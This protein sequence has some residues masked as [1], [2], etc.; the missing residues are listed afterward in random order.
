MLLRRCGSLHTRVK[1]ADTVDPFPVTPPAPS[2]PQCRHSSSGHSLSLLLL[3]SLRG[4][5]AFWSQSF[6]SSIAAAAK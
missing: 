3:L 4:S 5:A 2:G 1:A 6:P